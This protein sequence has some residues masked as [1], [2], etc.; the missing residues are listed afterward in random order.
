MTRTISRSIAACIGS[1]P[2]LCAAHDLQSVKPPRGRDL[3]V[4]F[5][6]TD[7]PAHYTDVAAARI[8]PLVQ[9]V[10]FGLHESRASFGD[11]HFG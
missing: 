9:F 6:A 7:Y 3:S 11:G 10:Q 1:A 8:N 4:S 2:V 5:D